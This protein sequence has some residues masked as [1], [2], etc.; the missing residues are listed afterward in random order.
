MYFGSVKFFKHLIFSVIILILLTPVVI[1]VVFI[2]KCNKLEKEL[3]VKTNALKIVEN[4]YK[5]LSIDDFCNIYYKNNFTSED[6][7]QGMEKYDLNLSD[8]IF[9][10]HFGV[11]N[12]ELAYQKKYSD[13]YV[14]APEEFILN[15]NVIYLTFDDGPSRSTIDILNILDKYNIKATF[16]VT[17]NE[18]EQGIAVLKEIVKRGHTIGIHSYSHDYKKIYSNVDA[19]LDDFYKAFDYVYKNT[20]VKPTIFRFPG[21]SVNTYN[22]TIYKEIISEMHRRGFVYYDWNVSGED[23]SKTATWT[24]IYNNVLNSLEGKSRAV[25][26]LHD[27]PSNATTI[28]VVEDLIINLKAKGYKFDK[29][30]NYDKP[31]TFGYIN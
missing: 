29:L 25:V 26:L 9:K 14:T 15:D 12:D 11:E 22:M 3:T 17:G 21:G 13:M 28:T 19:F 20:G 24:S 2:I 30:D 18:S 5:N 10:N 6:L 23:A 27:G 31:I 16:F 8:K 1:S 7:I 4:D